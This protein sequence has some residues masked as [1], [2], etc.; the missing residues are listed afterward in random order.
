[1]FLLR[2]PDL[3]K[4]RNRHREQQSDDQKQDHHF[5][6]RKASDEVAHPPH[7]DNR[8]HIQ[9]TIKAILSASALAIS[10]SLHATVIVLNN[11]DRLTGTVVERKDGK[12]Y[13]H[14][15]FL[16]ATVAVPEEGATIEEGPAPSPPSESLA[17][18]PPQQ[19]PKPQAQ[20]PASGGSPSTPT[21]AEVLSSAAQHPAAVKPVVSP[22]TGKVEFGYDNQVSN[23]IRVV[24]VTFR[25]EEERTF[26]AENLLFKGRF[27]YA[28]SGGHATTDEE[29]G[30]FRWR[31]NLSPRFFTQL[32]TTASSD[33]IQLVRYEIQENAGVGYRVFQSK[34]FTA[35]FGAGV[36]GQ[37]L[38]ATGIEQGFDYLGNVFQDV[39]Y[40]LNGRFT[41]TENASAQYSPETRSRY[42]FVPTI[43][44]P[45]SSQAQDYAYKF[46]TT[47][48][49]KL[50]DHLSLNLHFE[51]EFNNAILVPTNRAE[52]RTTTTVGYGF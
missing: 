34:P 33:K 21:H 50:T 9:G 51:Y 16:D 10:A 7:L 14:S 47:L 49:G 11:G 27:L 32:D 23:G 22:W 30:E 20:A 41:F 1:M 5:N 45:V 31:H 43:S 17:G 19:T 46:H 44:T 2:L 12:I 38:D 26:G 40:K 15:D 36:T 35:N 13:F 3:L 52:Q 4:S 48:Q 25:D 18:I 42:G 8:W 37:A 6:Q 39:T 24:N 29:D 28:M